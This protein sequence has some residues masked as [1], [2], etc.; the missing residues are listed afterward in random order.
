M[1]LLEVEKGA[2]ELKKGTSDSD[3]K[4]YTDKGIDVQLVDPATEKLEEEAGRKYTAEESTAVG[5]VVGKSL[6]K[7]LRAQGD[8]VV[9]IRLTGVGLN[10]FNIKVKY[11]NDKGH[12]L[13]K[14]DLNPD[15]ESI[16]L[17]LGSEPMELVDFVITQGNTVSLPTPELEDKLSDAMKKY[18]SEPSPEEYDQ[19]AAMEPESDPSQINKYIS[20]GMLEERTFNITGLGN[21]EFTGM[22]DGLVMGSQ[23]NGP[24]RTFKRERVL[25]DNPNFFDRQPR[26]RKPQ[27]VR[28]YT[29]AQY[30]KILQ[31]A[32]D[33]AGSTEFAYDIAD[34]M[35]YDPQI[36]AR[37]KKDYPEASARELKQQ[38]QYDL[39]ACDSPE[40]DYDD[41]YEGEVAETVALNEKK[42][43]Y[44]GRCGHTHVK[45]TPCP[46]PF[47]EGVV[48]EKLG[49]NTKP[50]TYIKDFAK[51][52]APQFK[53]KSAE[54]K[55]QMAI[56]AYMSNKNEGLD[57]VGKEDDDIN[58]DGKVDKTDKYL[59]NRR[60]VVSKNIAEGDIKPLPHEKLHGY[61][62]ETTPEGEHEVWAVYFDPKTDTYNKRHRVPAETVFG[63]NA[64]IRTPIREAVKDFFKD[65]MHAADA[66]GWV[67]NPKLTDA[68]RR[69]KIK[70]V[71]K[72]P[73]KFN[74]LMDAFTDELGSVKKAIPK[75]IN[76][77]TNPELTKYVNRFVGGL[78]KMYDYSTQDAVYAIMEVLRSQ[79]W[80]GVN[81]DLDV[82]HQDNEP[83]MLKKDVYRIA[84]MASMLYKQLDNY[85][86]GQEVDFPHWW[87]AKIIKAYDYLQAAYGYLDGEEK[88]QQIDNSVVVAM[89]L[90]EKKL[91]NLKNAISK[92][93]LKEIMLEAYVEILQE[94]EGPELKTSTQEI[95]GKFPT[96]KKAVVSLLTQEFPEFIQDIKWVAP[97][98][99]TF[100]VVLKN[101]QPFY[102]KWTG[103][104]FD[105]QIEGKN[106]FLGSTSDYQQALDKLND[107][108]KNGPISQGEE[109]G[110]EEFGAAP[111]EPATG[112]GGGGEFP[113][114]EAAPEFGAEETPAGEEGGAEPETPEAL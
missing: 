83:A 64:S 114:G 9:D 31:G 105:A 55:R 56:A 97:K 85:D 79:G 39:E 38:L 90:N 60:D 7:V 52:D 44:C 8:E 19:M 70:A 86:N 73:S 77:I 47:K 17:D 94:E 13:F 76:E 62:S 74:K 32:I 63:K 51:S 36:L 54:K 72:D 66:R 99:S 42:A 112:G 25:Q 59:K 40:D 6:L 111:A 89:P 82:G 87:Q 50:E 61:T 95:L 80:K 15:T 81:E 109:P 108:F 68:Q 35:I 98:P 102:L 20:E 75:N 103:K 11:G 93:E 78:A 71:M 49:P 67:K 4:K 91:G 12:D 65:P 53:G 107:I 10:K 23:N 34:S 41:D 88:V 3:I 21:F 96:V 18:T 1:K 26:E 106:Y 110:G 48:G 69:D 27:G 28:P 104:G 84:K 30:W 100:Q 16:V 101:G 113:G 58:N 22:R 24:V 92:K 46:R 2:V 5:R 43:T 29:E 57:A 14:F 33:D 45:G 37:L